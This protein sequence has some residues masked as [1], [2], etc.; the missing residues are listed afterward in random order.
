[1]DVFVP[2]WVIP[3]VMNSGWKHPVSQA[4]VDDAAPG[5]VQFL[6]YCQE[7]VT[8][9]PILATSPLQQSPT[10]VPQVRKQCGGSNKIYH[11]HSNFD[12]VK[13]PPSIGSVGHPWNCANPCKYAHKCKDG[14]C[15]ERC[16]LCKWTRKCSKTTKDQIVITL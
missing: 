5:E 15:C 2:K 8:A 11:T 10:S 7:Q 14:H 16:H 13:L 3:E 4:D 1:M 12:A 9:Y 6:P